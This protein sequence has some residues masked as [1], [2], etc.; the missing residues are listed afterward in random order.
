MSRNHSGW[1]T[2]SSSA[3]LVPR[4]ARELK[5]FRKVRLDPG[6]TE[7]VTLSLGRRAFAYFDVAAHQWR[8]DPGQFLFYVGDAS[9]VTPLAA[10]F[11][12]VSPSGPTGD[13]FGP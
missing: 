8:I 3:R 2:I 9:D 1:S 13:R 4:P 5:G 12:Y 7:R 11:N 6:Q 10:D